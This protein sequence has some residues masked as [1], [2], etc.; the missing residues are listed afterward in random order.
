MMMRK[1]YTERVQFL[2]MKSL[3]NLSLQKLQS[4]KKLSEYI[5]MYELNKQSHKGMLQTAYIE[6]F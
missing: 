5:A 3:H 2:K 4:K 6:F 1:L